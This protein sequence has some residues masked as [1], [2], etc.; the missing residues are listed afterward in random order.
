MDARG[1]SRSKT[2]SINLRVSSDREIN[3]E[4]LTIK[5]PEVE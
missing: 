1:R 5:Q 3:G 4:K 2:P